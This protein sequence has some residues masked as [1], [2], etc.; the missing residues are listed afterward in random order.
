MNSANLLALVMREKNLT[1]YRQV[2]KTLGVTGS[3]VAKWANESSIPTDEH[4]VE[5]CKLAR[6]DAAQWIASIRFNNA[7]PRS[8]SAWAEIYTT[9]TASKRGNLPIEHL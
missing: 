9:V 7:D 1:S 2:G 4:I 8:R 6:E 5:L 3:N